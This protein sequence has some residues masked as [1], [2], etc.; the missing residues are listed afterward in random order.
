MTFG[1][2]ANSN[3]LAAESR[4]EEFPH[5]C[6][7]A[8]QQRIHYSLQSWN[9]L[10][11]RDQLNHKNCFCENLP[12]WILE[13]K[14]LSTVKQASQ[15]RPTRVNPVIYHGSYLKWFYLKVL[16]LKPLLWPLFSSS[17]NVSDNSLFLLWVVADIFKAT[18]LTGPQIQ[19]DLN[20]IVLG[21]NMLTF[22]Q[23]LVPV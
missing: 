8:I 14:I 4:V 13:I 5:K 19:N 3:Q 10:L 18:Y 9:I 16:G 20:M 23:S 21:W 17:W 11:M 12:F 7:S 22:L 15:A 1:S 6:F 2:L